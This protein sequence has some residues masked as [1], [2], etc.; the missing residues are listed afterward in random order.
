[1]RDVEAMKAELKALRTEKE[2]EK[3]FQNLIK[4]MDKADALNDRKHERKNRRADFDITVLDSDEELE[5]PIPRQFRELSSSDNWEDIIFSRRPEGLHE[6]VTDGSLI[7][8]LKGLSKER[9]EALFYRGVWRYT[10]R[11]IAA[12]KGVSDRN[13][14]KLYEKAIREIHEKIQNKD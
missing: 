13:V 11:E 9:K 14:R 2:R 10:P 6:L 7:N 8:A 3:Y 5:T 4:E 12:L 1:M